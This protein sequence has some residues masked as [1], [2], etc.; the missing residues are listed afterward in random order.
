VASPSINKLFKQ[1]VKEIV[2]PVFIA[3][4]YVAHDRTF[5]EQKDGFVKVCTV[6]K[7]GRMPDKISLVFEI[8][9]YIPYE[10]ILM[11]AKDIPFNKITAYHC[12]RYQ[13]RIYLPDLGELKSNGTWFSITEK[14]KLKDIQPL[15]LRAAEK[16]LKS[17][18]TINTIY[19]LLNTRELKKSFNCH[20]AKFELG[21]TLIK[22]GD[23]EL[24]MKLYQEGF[25]HFID[26]LRNRA[27]G[28]IEYKINADDEVDSSKNL[29]KKFKEITLEL[30]IPVDCNYFM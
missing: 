3:E 14:T 6:H 1:I 30:D 8:G 27:A 24:G 12:W 26:F 7:D 13:E 18:N 19:D 23:R 2:K 10:S 4:G 11:I 28:E 16:N 20:P 22:L 21:L 15:I 25:P 5:L 29:W 9:C 17:L